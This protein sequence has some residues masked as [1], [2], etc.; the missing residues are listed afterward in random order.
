MLAAALLLSAVLPAQSPDSAHLVLIATTD[1]HGHVTEWDYVTDA[2][3]PGGLTRAATVI[4][5]IRN[6]Y[7]DQVVLVDGGDLFEGDLFGVYFARL[8]PRDPHPVL[9][10]LNGMGYDVGTFGEHEFEYGPAE[11][12]RILAG[13]HFPYV[14]G[15]IRVPGRDTLAYS[16][17]TVVRRQGLRVG[18]TGFT[19]PGVMVWSRRSLAGQLRVARIE[20]SADPVMQEL[21]KDADLVVVL[22]HTGLSGPS[23]YDTTGVGAENVAVSLSQ[24]ATRPD[25]VIVGHSHRVLADTVLNGVHFVQPAAFGQGLA[26]VHVDLRRQGGVW[27]MTRVR[28][29]LVSLKTVPISAKIRRRL[30]DA[31]AAVRIWAAKPAAQAGSPMQTATARAE[32]TPLIQ[33][34]T[35][36]MRRQAHADLAATPVFDLRTKLELGPITN[37]EVF[38][39]YPAEYT[40]RAVRISGSALTAYLEQS[41][42]YFYSDTTGRVAVNALAS[43]LNYDI[44]GGAQYSIDLTQPPG[45]RIR[46][47]RV[48]G[49]AVQPTDSF[50]LALSSFRQSGG[51]NFA[52][53]SAA[54]VVYDKG[55]PIRDLILADLKTRGTLQPEAFARPGWRIV[56]A[57]AA[58]AAR[59]L[60]A[61]EPRAEVRSAPT[62][63]TAG[64]LF[65]ATRKDSGARTAPQI[66]KDTSAW[67]ATIKTPMMRRTG[68]SALGALVADAYRNLGRAD[69]A[70]VSR[71][72]LR[73]DLP[74][75]PLTQA[76]AA[77]ILEPGHQ[78]KKIQM[79]GADLQWVFENMVIG[80]EPCCQLSG[81]VVTFDPTRKD[82]ERVKDVRQVGTK[83]RFDPKQTYTLVISDYLVTEGNSF[84]LGASSCS[85]PFGC[86]RSGLLGRWPVEDA[87]STL[88]A[89]VTYLRRVA[90][91]VEPPEDVRVLAKP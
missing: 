86:A 34:V 38:G 23:T 57:A 22:A 88:E 21:R 72:E 45:R 58:T 66:R 51:G 7:P 12:V 16:A 70:I 91:P 76:G 48:G 29:Q 60:W 71:E 65:A 90:Q 61:K 85:A 9:D 74:S 55:E 64:R 68:P 20:S 81:A 42:R 84:P 52:M 69:L 89:F 41:A 36:V 11:M 46:D 49:R 53:L 37:A 77:M 82:W 15:N 18:V 24:I 80:A 40:L 39:L 14:S 87:G 6:Q 26:V 27:R 17:Y 8:A 33:Y 47:L 62:A 4:D 83:K 3:Y 54:P 73:A 30:A 25:L 43:P 79:P 75:G 13:A 31:D 10:V 2:S 59:A 1:L 78:L 63:D 19:T 56:P 67:V 44:V 5:S 35:D 28:A 32:D 50:T